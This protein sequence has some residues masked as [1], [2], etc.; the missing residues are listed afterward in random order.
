MKHEFDGLLKLL[1]VVALARN[2]QS[3]ELVKTKIP[4]WAAS[5]AKFIELAVTSKTLKISKPVA[6]SL[7]TIISTLPA[8]SKKGKK[9]YES[10]KE[11]VQTFAGWIEANRKAGAWQQFTALS[12]D[13]T[14]FLDTLRKIFLIDSEAGERWLQSKVNLLKE[15]MLSKCFA[16]NLDELLPRPEDFPLE[17]KRKTDQQILDMLV[18]LAIDLGS[19]KELAPLIHVQKTA[20]EK[21][22]ASFLLWKAG[23]VYLSAK[24]K[25]AVSK[26][27]RNYGHTDIAPVPVVP[28]KEMSQHL[29]EY[30]IVWPVVNPQLKKGEL[31]A[32]NMSLY[33]KTGLSLGRGVP[34][35]AKISYNPNY[36][37]E[38]T[39]KFSQGRGGMYYLKLDFAW[40]GSTSV[41]PAGRANSNKEKTFA[42]VESFGSKIDTFRKKWTAK[43]T[44]RDPEE[45][46]GATILEIVYQS[47]I[48]IGSRIGTA[49]VEGKDVKTYGLTVLKGKHMTKVGN[50]VKLKYIGKAGQQQT[51]M[52]KPGTDAKYK[53]AIANLVSYMDGKDKNDFVF[54]LPDGTRFTSLMANNYLKKITGSSAISIHKFRHIKANAIAAPILAECPFL[55]KTGNNRVEVTKWFKENMKQVG[56]ALGHFTAGEVTGNTAIYAYIDPRISKKF[57]EDCNVQIPK[58]IVKLLAEEK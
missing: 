17:F 20:R 19:P 49:V 55:G 36:T 3:Y 23:Q 52:L 45:R 26:I 37:P 43:L 14:T 57:F 31:M 40:G 13:Q 35:N 8:N 56:E 29:K 42:K 54:T 16:G 7:A 44:S 1:T 2:G 12:L 47:S 25:D 33:T 46:M 18:D 11:E 53:Q 15:P 30:G 28:V 5:A 21:D 4:S 6:T 48:R 24:A 22:E 58:E 50:N 41:A 10:I 39:D 32:D 38:Y 27:V 51:Q 34:F 9:Y